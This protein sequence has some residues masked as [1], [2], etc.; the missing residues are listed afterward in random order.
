[1]PDIKSASDARLVELVTSANQ[2]HRRFAQHELVR[3]GPTPERVALLEKR[4]LASGPLPARVSA[5]F[6]LKQLAGVSAHGVL[7]KAAAD[8]RDA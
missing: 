8:P 1:M 3:R 7:V 2:I 4:V 5:L 6:T